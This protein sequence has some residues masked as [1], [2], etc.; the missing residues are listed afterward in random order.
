ML[1]NFIMNV[2]SKIKRS[3]IYHLINP[4][5]PINHE[6]KVKSDTC[7]SVLVVGLVLGLVIFVRLT[8]SLT[9]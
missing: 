4:I 8:L 6:F 1:T 5:A 7:G 9:R 3:G 2:L